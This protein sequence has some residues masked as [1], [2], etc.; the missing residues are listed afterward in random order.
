MAFSPPHHHLDTY[1]GALFGRKLWAIFPAGHTV[2]S[3]GTAL[4]WWANGSLAESLSALPAHER[5][6]LFVQRPG[7]LVYVPG[8]V[9]H[10]VINVEDA[11]G[12]VMEFYDGRPTSAA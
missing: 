12:L 8:G 10:A 4:G 5:P 9:A 11:L 1:N 2:F 3:G 7:D 6:A